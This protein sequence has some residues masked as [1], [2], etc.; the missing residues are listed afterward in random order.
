[1]RYYSL[2]YY[3]ELNFCFQCVLYP[4]IGL[5]SNHKKWLFKAIPLNLS[6]LFV[7]ILEIIRTFILPLQRRKTA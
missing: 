1:M 4:R 3:I 7:Q 6:Y 5:S 2:L